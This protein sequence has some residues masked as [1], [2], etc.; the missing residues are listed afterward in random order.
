MRI[1]GQIA[2]HMRLSYSLNN[3][4]NV[5]MVHWGVGDSSVV[6][7]APQDTQVLRGCGFESHQVLLLGPRA[8]GVLR[9]V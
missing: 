7:P 4:P 9:P 2:A 5:Y 8:T 3:L 1:C 6:E